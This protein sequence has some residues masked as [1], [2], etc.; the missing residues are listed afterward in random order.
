MALDE[1]NGRLVV[2]Y[3]EPALLAVF[4]TGSG[5][6][7]ARLP[8][9]GDTDDVFFDA[10][11]HGSISAAARAFSTSS[12]SVT[13]LT[14]SSHAFR[15]ARA[16][17]PRCSFPSAIVS[18]S[19]SGPAAARRS[20]LGLP[21]HAVALTK[22]AM[23]EV[24]YLRNTPRQLVDREPPIA[25]TELTASRTDWHSRRPARGPDRRSLCRPRDLRPRAPWRIHGSPHIRPEK[26]YSN[27]LKYQAEKVR[28]QFLSLRQYHRSEPAL[29]PWIGPLKPRE[30]RTFF[31]DGCAPWTGARGSGSLSDARLSLRPFTLPIRYPLHFCQIAQPLSRSLTNASLQFLLGGRDTGSKRIKVHFSVLVTSGP[32]PS[33]LLARQ[34]A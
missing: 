33:R 8:V 2:V 25:R 26:W 22:P 9:C 3:R 21:A 19:R 5:T 32:L 18:I 6:P 27:S 7:V 23:L 15:P 13:T 31:A 10:K 4:D 34:S 30:S 11:R 24:H 17:V 29:R 14:S 20:R 16:P 1:A 28:R 12:S